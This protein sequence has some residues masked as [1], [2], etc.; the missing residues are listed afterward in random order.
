M[1]ACW[2]STR[3][4]FAGSRARDRN[5]ALPPNQFHF[6]F[7]SSQK[8]HLPQHSASFGNETCHR[9]SAVAYFYL[10]SLKI[11]KIRQHK[12]SPEPSTL[13]Y[14]PIREDFAGECFIGYIAKGGVTRLLAI[15]QRKHSP[16]QNSDD[17]QQSSF[18]EKGSVG[19][20]RR[21]FLEQLTTRE[22]VG[23]TVQ[24]YTG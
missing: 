7:V 18:A 21:V 23:Q 13:T 20:L 15:S 5:P 2:R 8:P 10:V 16:A 14:R 19:F 12:N 22:I 9:L 24:V 17:D 6:S 4:R 11:D 1:A 3:K